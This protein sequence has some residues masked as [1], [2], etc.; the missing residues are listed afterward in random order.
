[1]WQAKK[2]PKRTTNAW[3]GDSRPTLNTGSPVYST[4]LIGEGR[5]FTPPAG[6]SRHIAGCGPEDLDEAQFGVLLSLFL[7][8][9][10]SHD[11]SGKFT[12]H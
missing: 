9:F 8:L 3:P 5:I 6:S 12:T 10:Q 4:A 7:A 1:M 11:G 2:D